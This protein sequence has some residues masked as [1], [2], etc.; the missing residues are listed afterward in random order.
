MRMDIPMNTTALVFKFFFVCLV[1]AYEKTAAALINWANPPELDWTWVGKGDLSFTTVLE[2]GGFVFTGHLK[3]D[4]ETHAQYFV[5][6]GT[7][8]EAGCLEVDAGRH[9]YSTVSYG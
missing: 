6:L 1:A 5:S 7:V 8:Y 3:P 4:R 9:L 2:E